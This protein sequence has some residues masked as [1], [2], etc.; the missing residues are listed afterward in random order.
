[1]QLTVLYCLVG[2]HHR[3]LRH[4]MDA[5]SLLLRFVTMMALTLTDDPGDPD[6]PENM[7]ITDASPESSNPSDGKDPLF[8]NTFSVKFE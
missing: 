2:I 1:M 6:P 3:P 8:N 5:S 4:P 7:D